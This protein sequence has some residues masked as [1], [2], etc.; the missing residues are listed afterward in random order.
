MTGL[1]RVA[2]DGWFWVNLVDTVKETWQVLQMEGQKLFSV[3]LLDPFHV[4][5]DTLEVLKKGVKARS[6]RINSL[7]LTVRAFLIGARQGE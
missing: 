3:T 4:S 6:A 1:K 2:H 5:K 7:T